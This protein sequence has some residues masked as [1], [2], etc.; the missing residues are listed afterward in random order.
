MW[1]RVASEKKIVTPVKWVRTS[2]PLLAGSSPFPLFT[3][4]T[5]N[6]A[7]PFTTGTTKPIDTPTI[8][9]YLVYINAWITLGG[10]RT[11]LEVSQQY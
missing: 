3:N 6:T 2:A 4:H 1:L 7:N 9:S 10:T 11:G 8:T 5:P